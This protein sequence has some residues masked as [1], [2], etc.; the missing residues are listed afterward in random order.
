MPKVYKNRRLTFTISWRRIQSCV[1]HTSMSLKIVVREDSYFFVCN[2]TMTPN[3]FSPTDKH[4]KWMSEEGTTVVAMCGNKS[5]IFQRCTSERNPR[6][7][8][9]DYSRV[10]QTS[11]WVLMTRWPMERCT[12]GWSQSRPSEVKEKDPSDRSH[13]RPLDVWCAE[14]IR[15]LGVSL[16]SAR[17]QRDF[18]SDSKDIVLSSPTPLNTFVVEGAVCGDKWWK[19]D[20]AQA[21]ESENFRGLDI[22]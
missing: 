2:C 16:H 13:S 20:K 12:Y 5:R 17:D 15:C 10:G 21:A 14:C 1:P 8:K 22:C 11:C 9:A 4:S 18:W 6:T 19:V 3:S 7:G